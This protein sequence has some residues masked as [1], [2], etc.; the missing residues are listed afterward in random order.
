MN[1]CEKAV[2]LEP[3]VGTYRD[4]RGV[5]RALTGNISGAIDDFRAY[6]RSTGVP[7]EEYH[8]RKSWIDMLQAGKNPFTQEEIKKLLNQ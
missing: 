6:M 5:A 7:V 1:A 4:S 2:N 3:Q 8:Q